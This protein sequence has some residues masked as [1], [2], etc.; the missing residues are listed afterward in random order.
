MKNCVPR[1][2]QKYYDKINKIFCIGVYKVTK[3]TIYILDD[4]EL[5]LEHLEEEYIDFGF[6]VVGKTNKPL[7]AMEELKTDNPDYL[8]LDIIMPDMDGI[9]IFRELKKRKSNCQIIFVSALSAE[10]K[11]VTNFQKEIEP[12]RFLTKPL[13]KENLQAF[14]VNL[15]AKEKSLP[16]ISIDGSKAG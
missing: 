12:F 13:S 6:E 2:N 8:S 5:I 1:I 10:T 16:T 4:N 14:L 11:F 9:E 3:K 7:I 15:E